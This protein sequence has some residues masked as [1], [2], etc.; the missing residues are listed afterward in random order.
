MP[1]FQIALFIETSLLTIGFWVTPCLAE[2]MTGMHSRHS[3]HV[4]SC[5]VLIWQRLSKHRCMHVKTS[6]FRQGS[7]QR[8]WVHLSWETFIKATWRIGQFRAFHGAFCQ[9]KVPWPTATSPEMM[10]LRR[11]HPPKDKQP[12]CCMFRTCSES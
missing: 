3:S 9:L 10:L 1:E 2:G 11:R 8:V 6:G 7:L 12:A 4:D 5:N